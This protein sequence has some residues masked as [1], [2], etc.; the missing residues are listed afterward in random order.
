MSLHKGC[1]RRGV[2][3]ADVVLQQLRIGQRC[4]IAQ[5]NT[6]AKMQ[7]G[8]AAWA[9]RHVLPFAMTAI[10]LCLTTTGRTRFDTLFSTLLA[11]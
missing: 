6:S 10:D 7:D 5:K 2:A 8:L 3:A 1:Y 11:G 9:G 4:Y